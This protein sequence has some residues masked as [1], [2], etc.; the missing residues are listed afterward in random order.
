LVHLQVQ[1]AHDRAESIISKVKKPSEAEAKA[2]AKFFPSS[3]KPK[4]VTQA[5]DP[6]AESVVSSQQ[7]KKK[8]AIRPKQRTVSVSVVMMKKYSST[9]PKGKERQSL[10]SEG[11]I[12]NMKVTRGMSAK[13]IKDKISKAFE[14][15]N[16]TVLECDG[17]GHSLIKCCDQEIDGDAVAQRRGCLYLCET[18]RVC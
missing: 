8:A 2:L 11:R 15:Q 17:N 7:K 10:A 5:F 4:A 18:F 6:S 13:E 16:Y 3:T 1:P 9:I 12:L 14:V